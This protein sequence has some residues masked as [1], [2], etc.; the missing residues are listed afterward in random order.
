MHILWDFCIVHN[1]ISRNPRESLR[2]NKSRQVLIVRT[3]RF[4]RQSHIY[5]H[6]ITK[7]HSC[8][9]LLESCQNLHIVQP[10][11][12]YFR[13]AILLNVL[14]LQ[15]VLCFNSIFK[16]KNVTNKSD[17]PTHDIPKSEAVVV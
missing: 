14:L 11:I 3:H 8:S 13:A 2:I 5:S 6:K 9:Y 15:L 4:A 1:A 17:I 16:T 10:C 7:S 12:Y